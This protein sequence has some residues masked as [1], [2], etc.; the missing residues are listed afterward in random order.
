MS[1]V[2]SQPSAA[3]ASP[4]SPKYP[5]VTFSPRTRISPSSAIRMSTPAIGVPTD[6]LLVLNGWLRV[7]MGA[8]SV[9]P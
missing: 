3:T 4:A 6:P 5:L 8:V 9:S 7:T 1:P 2:C